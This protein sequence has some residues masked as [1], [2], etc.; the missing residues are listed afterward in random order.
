MS[1][2]STSVGGVEKDSFLDDEQFYKPMDLNA[3]GNTQK[4]GAAP[5]HRGVGDSNFS[6]E[7]QSIIN[8]IQNNQMNT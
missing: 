8:Q 2:A 3:V 7:D 4:G 1:Q 6:N 5:K